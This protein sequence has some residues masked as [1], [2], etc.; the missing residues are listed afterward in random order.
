M[1]GQS[2]NTNNNNLVH[3]EAVNRWKKRIQE[4]K[5]SGLTQT[6]WCRENSVSISSFSVWK[7]KLMEEEEQGFTN[8]LVD[9][10]FALEESPAAEYNIQRRI[11]EQPVAATIEFPQYKVHVY[12]GAS[13]DVLKNIM[14]AMTHA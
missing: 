10:S 5:E 11:Y 8:D 7:R 9:I 12:E 6:E 2:L 13:S 14:E 4:H 1:N 3:L